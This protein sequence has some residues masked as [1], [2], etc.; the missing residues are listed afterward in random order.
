[1]R[2]RTFPSALP[3]M[4]GRGKIIFFFY[5]AE[6]AIPAAL[7]FALPM[8]VREGG[9]TACTIPVV[10]AAARIRNRLPALLLT[11]EIRF[12]AFI[13]FCFAHSTWNGSSTLP[14]PSV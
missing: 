7:P 2:T 6:L 10:L 11:K 4:I 8:K 14:Q 12:N 3:L 9:R 1:M 5:V 13:S